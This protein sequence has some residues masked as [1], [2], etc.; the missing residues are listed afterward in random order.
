MRCNETF[1]WTI[2]GGTLSFLLGLNWT[3]CWSRVAGGHITFERSWGRKS[4]QRRKQRYW[5]DWM[6]VSPPQIH[7]LKSY[8]NVMVLGDRDFGSWYG[9]DEGDFMDEMKVLFKRDRRELSLSFH[10]VRTRQGDSHLWAR[11][12]AHIRHSWLL[13]LRPPSLQNCEKEGFAV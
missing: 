6:F 1:V 7:M 10:H 9:H 2:G 4:P 12:R 8:S 13:E 3:G 11:K 5:I